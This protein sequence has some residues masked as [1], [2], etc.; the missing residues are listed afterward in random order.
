[1]TVSLSSEN[2]EIISCVFNRSSTRNNGGAIAAENSNKITIISSRFIRNEAMNIGGAVYVH[3]TNHVTVIGSRFIENKAMGDGGALYVYGNSMILKDTLFMDN[4]AQNYGGAVA[5]VEHWRDALISGSFINNTGKC[6][7]AVYV[8][9]SSSINLTNITAVGNSESALC[10]LNPPDNNDDTVNTFLATYRRSLRYSWF[11]I[12]D[13]CSYVSDPISQLIHGCVPVPRQH[14]KS[15]IVFTGKTTIAWNTGSSGGG[16]HANYARLTFSGTTTI[17]NNSGRLGGGLCFS[18]S[19]VSLKGHALLASNVAEVHGGAVYS[20]DGTLS[21]G[22]DT[23]VNGNIAHTNGGALYAIDTRITVKTNIT[24]TSNSAQNGGAMW[25]DTCSL[26]LNENATL[27]TSHNYASLYG[28]AIYHKDE[29]SSSVC[30]YSTEPNYEDCFLGFDNHNQIIITSSFDLAG[31]D[32]SFLYGGLLD[33]CELHMSGNH[34]YSPYTFI[35]DNVF[36]ITSD[37]NQTISSQPYGI[38]CF[39]DIKAKTC[40]NIMNISVFRGQKFSVFVK[41]IA[42]SGSA[43]ANVT[44]LTG[45]NARIHLKQ[46][47]QTIPNKC[48]KLSYNFYSSQGH[49]ELRLTTGGSCGDVGTVQVVIGVVLLPCP[50]PLIQLNEDCTCHKRLMKFPNV[51]CTSEESG[52][53]LITKSPGGSFW[54]GVSSDNGSY[55]GLILYEMCPAEYCKTQSDVTVSLDDLDYQCDHNRGG[56]LCGEC[57]ANHSLMLGSSK[58]KIC[59]NAHLALLLPFAAAGVALVIFLTFL[60]LTVATGLIN[61]IILYANIVQVNKG[62]FFPVSKGNVL[63]VFIAWLNL[64]LGIQ[65]CFYDGM[66]AY[67]QTWLQFAFPIYVWLLIALIIISSRYSITLSKFIGR[68][69][70]AVLATLLLMSYTKILKIIIEVYSSVELEYPDNETVTV[71]LKDAN[72]PYLESWHLLLTIV[73]SIV[74]I[75][76]F[77]PYTALLLFGYR[78]YHLSGRKC[79]HLLDRIKPLLDSYYG[80]CNTHAR[81]WTG[82]LLLVRCALYIVFLLNSSTASTSLLAIIVTFTAVGFAMGILYSGRIYKSFLINILEACMYLNLIVLSAITQAG[83]ESEVFVYSLVG[84]VFV[85]MAFISLHQ[86]HLHYIAQTA[87]WLKLMEKWMH[88]RNNLKDYRANDTEQVVNENRII[89]K[90]VIELREPLIDQP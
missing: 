61:S 9:R 66:T 75:L 26:T 19:D 20:K 77:L 68:N 55:R 24:F 51:K 80:P 87:P 21:L 88:Y 48:S 10:F 37:H 31:R 90:T 3:N 70:I 32:G 14:Y 23:L 11:G 73:T 6:G 83:L 34:N 39:C 89:T 45:I 81:Y 16:I 60:R 17:T 4:M 62:I 7:G 63:T 53:T 44:A 71:W 50:H 54:I 30:S 22:G 36:N 57:I 49:D 25:L 72:I 67:A 27:T 56:V 76:L 40:N 43:S 38:L 2:I 58:C 84:L 41:S 59:T 78:L 52:K 42:Q 64:D 35:T 12:P 69:P 65:T 79:F 18:N 13:P 46:V 86:F 74:L 5:I 47:T 8:S 85:T 15:N 1:M 82:F 33:K 28:G 29:P